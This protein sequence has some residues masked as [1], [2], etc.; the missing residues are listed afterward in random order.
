MRIRHAITALCVTLAATLTAGAAIRGEWTLYPTFDGYPQKI[1]PTPTKTYVLSLGEEYDS[2]VTELSSR[3]GFLTVYDYEADEMTSYHSGNY[4]SDDVISTIQYNPWKKYLFI[5]YADGNI[6]LLYDD[7][8]VTNIP[9]LKNASMNMSKTIN[10]VLFDKDNDNIYIATSFGYLILDGSTENVVESRVYNRSLNSVGRVGDRLV[11]LDDQGAYW[12][13]YGDKAF[14][15]SDFHKIPGI[16]LSRLLM[17]FNDGSFGCIVGDKSMRRV[18]PTDD[19]FRV[20]EV[21]AGSTVDVSY[22]RDGYAMCNTDVVRCA[23][24]DGEIQHPGRGLN[25]SDWRGLNSTWDMKEFWHMGMQTGLTSWEIKDGQ[26]TM[27]RDKMF[28]NSPAVYRANYITYSPKYGMLINNHGV[29]STFPTYYKGYPVLL[30]G[31]KDGVWTR[32]GYPYTNAS[33]AKT[34]YYPNGVTIDPDNPDLVYY[35]SFMSGIQRM[36]LADPTDMRLFSHPKDPSSSLPQYSQLVGDSPYWDDLCNFIAPVF[37]AKGYMWTAYNNGSNGQG[38]IF[39]VWPPEGRKAGDAS[40]FV[41][42]TVPNLLI[43][44][45]A[46]VLPLSGSGQ[47]NIV[48]AST[49]I[50]DNVIIVLDH[51]GTPEDHSDDKVVTIPQLVDQDGNKIDHNYVHWL[52]EDRSTGNVW[53]GAHNGVFY[54]NPKNALAGNTRVTRI[55]VARNDGTNLADYLLDNVPVYSIAVDRDGNKWFATG[56]GGLVCTSADGRSI[57]EE[58]NSSNSLIPDDVVY[59]IGYNPEENSFLVSTAKGNARFRITSGQGTSSGS[60]DANKAHI[61]PNPV[62]PDYLGWITIDNLPDNGIVKIT[63]AAGSLVKE[64]GP[65]SGGLVRWDGTNMEMKRVASGVYHVFSTGGPDDSNSYA[66]GKVLIVK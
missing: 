48:V 11:V 56:G 66:K 61:Y 62:R 41:S 60:D 9:T 21:N 17:P 33:F 29:N 50:F 2:S 22:C 20:T 40:K 57:E 59:G 49:G 51:A 15:F 43:N 34:L 14:A 27:T 16:E 8:T 38:F 36:N 64:L 46:I 6:D 52:H 63:D 37:D 54:F 26:L 7:N 19:S 53:I 28:P 30:S 32:Y 39:Y 24:F 5:G 55:K 44:K 42:F 10:Q 35:G 65:A 18:Y 47:Q 45:D 58:I 13:S 12:V 25:Y 4:L 31:L 1:V 23:T 3:D